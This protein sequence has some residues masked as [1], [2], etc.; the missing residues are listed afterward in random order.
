MVASSNFWFGSSGFYPYE[1]GQSC[2]FNSIGEPLLLV[3]GLNA[4]LYSQQIAQQIQ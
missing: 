3:L 2:R 4:Q 1:I